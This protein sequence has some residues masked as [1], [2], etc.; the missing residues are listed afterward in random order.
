M[1]SLLQLAIIAARK[2]LL[3][4]RILRRNSAKGSAGTTPDRSTALAVFGWRSQKHAVFSLLTY[5]VRSPI[6]ANGKRLRIET[7]VADALLPTREPCI[8]RPSL[9]ASSRCASKR[10]LKLALA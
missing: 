3:W 7:F 4:Q 8:L 1:R 2:H 5:L 6:V 9:F 10:P